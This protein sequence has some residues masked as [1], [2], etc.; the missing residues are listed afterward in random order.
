MYERVSYETL[1]A[2]QQENYNFHQVAARLANYGFNCLRLTDDWRGAD[3]IACHID[4]DT[5]LK[6]QLKGRLVIDKRYR[7]KSIF[8]AFLD[9]TDCYVYPHDKFL[10]SLIQLGKLGE[11]GG[12]KGWEEKG[13]RHWPIMPNW[14]RD[15]LSDYRI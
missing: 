8:I 13:H 10:E 11:R 7:G 6:V 12:L 3:F 9:G 1:N 4:G 5:F 2:R 14:A 15:L